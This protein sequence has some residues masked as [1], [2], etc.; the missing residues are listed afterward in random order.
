MTTKPPAWPMAPKLNQTAA[1]SGAMIMPSVSKIH[2]VPIAIA[3]TIRGVN[4]ANSGTTKAPT[5]A[6]PWKNAVK[7]PAA[8]ALTPRSSAMSV[9]SQVANP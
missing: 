8:A 4:R 9:G 5:T 7:P 6:T 1:H 3:G 2:D